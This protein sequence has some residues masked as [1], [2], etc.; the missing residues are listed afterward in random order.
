VRLRINAVAAVL[1]ANRIPVVGIIPASEQTLV[2]SGTLESPALSIQFSSGYAHLQR[3]N[4]DAAG[5]LVSV[6][7]FDNGTRDVNTLVAAA[8]LTIDRR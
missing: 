2:I 1:R 7:Y 6:T 5:E 8:R 3:H 4:Y